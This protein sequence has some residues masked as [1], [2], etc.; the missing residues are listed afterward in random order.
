M[1]RDNVN[2][3]LQAIDGCWD[4]DPVG[5]GCWEFRIIFV[6]DDDR[7]A[8][9]GNDLLVCVEGLGKETITGEDHDDGEVFVNQGEDTVFKLTR[10]DSFAMEIRDFLDLEGACE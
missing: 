4:L 1:E 7:P 8:L 9:A 2:Q 6:A 5:L 3:T 10:H